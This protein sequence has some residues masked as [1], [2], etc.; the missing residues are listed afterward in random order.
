MSAHL[1]KQGEPS[2][3]LSGVRH[4]WG[5]KCHWHHLG[6]M[7]STPGPTSLSSNIHAKHFSSH[8]LQ[9]KWLEQYPSSRDNPVLQKASSAF[10]LLT[11]FLFHLS[12]LMRDIPLY[13]HVH[14][15]SFFFFW[16]QQE[17]G[18]CTDLL[19]SGVNLASTRCLLYLPSDKNVLSLNFAPCLTLLT[20]E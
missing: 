8:Y 2:Q 10:G 13:W 4:R 19:L 15:V 1:F 9:R 5:T 16:Q 12:C 11:Q 20:S 18:D 3:T 14:N 7:C 17:V 6:S